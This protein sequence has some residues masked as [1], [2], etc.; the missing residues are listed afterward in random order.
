VLP[1]SQNNPILQKLWSISDILQSMNVKVGK[2]QPVSVS[3]FVPPELHAA[4]LKSAARED[5]SL[6]SL[7]RLAAREHL[8]RAANKEREQ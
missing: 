3:L 7:L 1:G 5:R 6:S 4:L 8:E 2:G